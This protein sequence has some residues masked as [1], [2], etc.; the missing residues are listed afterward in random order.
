MPLS[1]RQHLALTNPAYMRLAPW[2]SGGI[3]NLKR[4]NQPY[5]WLHSY[6]AEATKFAL[7]AFCL[8]S[9]HGRC[10]SRD[11]VLTYI[12]RNCLMMFKYYWG[13]SGRYVC[14]WL[15]CLQ[16]RNWMFSCIELIWVVFHCAG[17]LHRNLNVLNNC[18]WEVRS[19]DFRHSPNP[20]LFLNMGQISSADIRFRIWSHTG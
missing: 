9:L 20:R 16:T 14:N 6:A 12:A 17:F 18:T 7:Q 11:Y 19:W 5:A 3:H 13:G 1:W 8:S 4:R 15:M 10:Q 2:S